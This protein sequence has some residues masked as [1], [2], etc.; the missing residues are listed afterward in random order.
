M[1][2]PPRWLLPRPHE[3]SQVRLA[4]WDGRRKDDS[5]PSGPEP[6]A[7]RNC[8]FSLYRI[9][10]KDCHREWTHGGYFLVRLEDGNKER[11][12]GQSKHTQPCSF[13]KYLTIQNG[14]HGFMAR[15]ECLVY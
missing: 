10:W 11:L 4:S 9:P 8:S 6:R 15:N 7:P 14:K 2:G 12:F 1:F 5:L 13:C 3:Y